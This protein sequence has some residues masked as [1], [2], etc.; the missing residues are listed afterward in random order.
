LTQKLQ[1][2]FGALYDYLVN[3]D[4]VWDC[5]EERSSRKWTLVNNGNKAFDADT[6][7]LPFTDILVAFD[8]RHRYPH[9]PHPYPLVPESLQGS[10]SKDV[11]LT[12]PKKAKPT[13]E[14]MLER[15]AA[16]AYS[17]AS[18]IYLLGSDFAANDLVDSFVRFEKTDKPAE[19]DPF[20][21]RRGRWVLIYG[22]LQVLVLESTSAWHSA[23]ERRG[24]RC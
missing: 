17:E 14:R 20:A 7:D 1:K 16:L 11:Q 4:I 3:R 19:V 18:N 2:D 6:H 24:G 13:E 5:S 21:A 12:S 15:R 10:P 9:I 8:N 23:M 22:I